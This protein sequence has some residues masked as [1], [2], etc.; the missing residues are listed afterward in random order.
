M[1]IG[2]LHTHPSGSLAPSDFDYQ[3]FLHLDLRIGRWL[4]YLIAGP[5][6][7]SAVYCTMESW[8]P[9]KFAELSRKIKSEEKE[10]KGGEKHAEES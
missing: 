1:V 3:L 7:R 4:K 5:D 10:G 8:N 9:E 6:G 2:L